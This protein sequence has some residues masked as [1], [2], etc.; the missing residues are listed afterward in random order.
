M[1]KNV[2][3]VAG[4]KGGVGKSVVAKGLVEW[5]LEGDSPVMVVDG[6]KRTPD[7]AAAFTDRLPVAEFDLHA[8]SGWPLFTDYLCQTD[9]QGAVVVN[10][11]DSLNDRAIH[12]LEPFAKLAKGYGYRIQVLFVMNALPDGLHLYARLTSLFEHVL[13]VKNLFFGK[14]NEFK[15]F[16]EAYGE[17]DAP[18][19]LFPA[20]HRRIMH[21]VRESNLSYLDFVSQTD[22]SPSNFVCAKVAVDIWRD[23]MLEAFDDSL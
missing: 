18:C 9:L 10:L 13:P 19:V 5:V 21:V 12:F 22:D 6:D 11:P 2:Y 20:L 8:D 4:N 14:P 17:E 7:V 15:H 23:E 16:D 3:L 1:P